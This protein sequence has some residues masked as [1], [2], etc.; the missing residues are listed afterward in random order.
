MSCAVEAKLQ[1][2]LQ[3]E[4]IMSSSVI[5]LLLRVKSAFLMNFKCA[6]KQSLVS[7]TKALNVTLNI[8]QSAFLNE[9][10]E[11]SIVVKPNRYNSLQ[12]AWNQ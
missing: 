9:C 2:I 11:S 3:T 7:D 5:S 6:H 10:L 8:L 12:S 4:L 1:R